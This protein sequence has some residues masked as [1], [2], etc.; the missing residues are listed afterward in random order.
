[1]HT[2]EIDTFQTTS[3]NGRNCLLKI[4]ELNPKNNPCE[5]FHF[6]QN[7]TSKILTKLHPNPSPIINHFNHEHTF[8]TFLEE[9]TI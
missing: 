5:H 4:K 6:I 8:G 1:M 2:L 9:K 3:T 7:T